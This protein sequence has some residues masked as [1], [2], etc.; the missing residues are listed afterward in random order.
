[1]SDRVE[2]SYAADV[3]SLGVCMMEAVLSHPPWGNLDELDV[4]IAGGSLPDCPHESYRDAW[5][6]ASE[7]CR[8]NPFER[9]QLGKVKTRL[10]RLSASRF[11]QLNPAGKFGPLSSQASTAST[12]ISS[13]KHCVTE[14]MYC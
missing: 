12:S 9:L 11:I 7:M 8:A 2:P 5:E 3:Y 13:G 14:N 6:V 4:L 1:M 10:D